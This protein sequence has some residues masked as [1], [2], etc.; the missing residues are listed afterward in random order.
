MLPSVAATKMISIHIFRRGKAMSRL[1]AACSRVDPATSAAIFVKKTAS[2]EVTVN[3]GIPDDT[4][5]R[6]YV[7]ASV[8]AEAKLTQ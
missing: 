5:E 7:Q 2:R 6:N 3:V 8:A 1:D 4:S